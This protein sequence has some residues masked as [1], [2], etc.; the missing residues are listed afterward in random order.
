MGIWE[1]MGTK[2]LFRRLFASGAIALVFT[3]A[4]VLTRCGGMAAGPSS[5][6][7]PS[8][9]SSGQSLQSVTTY[10][11][12]GARTGLNPQETTLSPA[13]VNSG[14]FGRLYSFSVDG[15][16]YAQPLYLPGVSIGGT[17]YN[18]IFVATEHDSVYAFDA[19][20]KTTT[21]LWH[22]SF[23]NP[24]AG[25]TPVD[26]A[27]DFPVPYDDIQPEVGITSTPAL[28]TGTGTLYVVAKTKENGQFVQRLHALDITTGAEKFSG[29]VTIQASVP[30]QGWNNVNGNIVF[31]PHINLQRAALLLANG[32]VYAAFASHGDFDPFHGWIIGYDAKT[33]KQVIAYTPTAQGA[34]G[35]VWQS[36]NGPATDGNGNIYV[37]TAN[38]D[39]I[40]GG[41]DF[42]DSFLRMAPSGSTFNIL[43][44]F[45]PSNFQT[46]NDLDQDLGSGGPVLLPDQSSGPAHLVIGGGKQKLVYVVNRDSMGHMVSGDSQVVQQLPLPGPLFGT[47]AVW[48]NN[49]YMAP[50]HAALQAYKLNGGQLT[51]SS[52]A[53]QTF[54]FPGSSPAVSSNGDSNA[55]VWAL[56]V[57]QY[58]NGPAILHAYDA[59][60]V[61]KELYNSTQ[62]GDRDQAPTAVKFSVPTVVNGKV[63]VG[64]G[65]ALAVYGLLPH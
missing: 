1:T 47:P 63:Y 50:V 58:D 51:L 20:G 49:V 26:S 6:T 46:L 9:S 60:D 17:T 27:T 52:T 37:I 19:D 53:P 38:G 48:G 16:I 35:G 22:Q 8:G 54:G 3:A 34:G 14:Q 5:G 39:Y 45:T 18:V 64:G 31:D 11:N 15:Q 61:S 57:D 40:D 23:I 32:V 55:I 59:T 65:G 24:A 28:D 12:D 41:P 21:P 42:G 56:Q 36:G 43:D 30:G 44:W 33:L 29:P 25:V 10:H 2:T 7:S 62:A 13:N 4:A